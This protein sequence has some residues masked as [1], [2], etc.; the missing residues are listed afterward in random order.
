MSTDLKQAKALT[1]TYLT[2]VSFA[3]LNGGDKEA[4]NM[5]NIKKLTRETAHGP[6]AYPYVS[7][8]AVRRALRERL[9]DFGCDLSEGVAA[10]QK[11]GA[12]TTLQNPKSYIDDDLF[13]YMEGTKGEGG[14]KGGTKKRTSPVRVSPLLAMDAYQGDLDFGTNYMSVKAGGDP[15]IFETEIHSGLYRGTILIELDRV[16]CGEG[17]EKG[18]LEKSER[19]KRV[20]AL[21]TAVQNLWTSGRQS[22]FLADISPKFVA[23]AATRVKAPIFLE[24]VRCHNGGLQTKTL[25]EVVAD[26]RDMLIAHT[27]GARADTFNPVPE[28]TVTVGEAFK[29]M[30]EWVAGYY[31]A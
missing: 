25:S 1:L 6:Q 5:V 16:G 4:D 27:Y 28:G 9:A 12:A 8:Q 21:L 2:P 15:N 30:Q 29:K 19:A 23:G 17:F 24:S 20:S 3:S 26:H 22:R 31:G 7:S 14:A 11:K 13:G 10:T 18:D